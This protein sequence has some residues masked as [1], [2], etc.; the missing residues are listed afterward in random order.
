MSIKPHLAALALLCS[1]LGTQAVTIAVQGP[2]AR[3]GLASSTVG[4]GFSIQSDATEWVSFIGSLLIDETTSSL[5]SYTDFIGLRGGPDGFALPPAVGT[6]LQFYDA[7]SLQGLG[8]YTLDPGA[9]A[10]SS[11]SATLRVLYERYSASPALCG[12]NCYLGSAFADLLVSVTAVPE[13][14]PQAL[15][16]AGL[17]AVA[18][19]QFSAARRRRA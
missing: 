6:W 3:T 12:G 5:G 4:W 8:S 1:S 17:A 2:A 10:G 16:A 9:L 18:W 15:L 19:L 11:N 13:P 14:S 7:P